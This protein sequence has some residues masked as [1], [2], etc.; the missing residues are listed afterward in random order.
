MNVL[1]NLKKKEN[2]LLFLILLAAFLM[3]AFRLGHESFWLDELHT[4]NEAAPEATIKQLFGW[5]STSDQHPPLFFFC[6]KLIFILFGS[7]EVSARLLPVLAGTASVYVLYL[8]GKELAGKNLGLIAAAFTCVNPFNIHYSREARGYM[9]AFLFAAASLLLLVRLIKCLRTHDMWYFALFSLL[10]MYSHYFGIFWVG[11]EFCVAVILYFYT[12]KTNRTRYLKRFAISAVVITAGYLAWIPFVLKM[13]QIHSFW[14]GQIGTDFVFSFFNSFYGSDG[15]LLPVMWV[16]LLF[17]V[18][19]VFRQGEQ[20]LQPPAENLLTLSFVIFFVTLGV[21]LAVPYVRSVM[22]VPMLLDR[23]TIVVLPVYLMAAAYGLDLIPNTL[24]KGLV[25]W[26]F[27]GWSFIYIVLTN[28]TYTYIHK[29][30]FREMTAYIS[31]DA[32]KRRYPVVNDRIMWQEGYYLRKDK[33][34]GPQLTGPRKEVIDSL[35]HGR[36]DKYKTDYFWIID[37]HGAGDPNAFLDTAEKRMLDSAFVLVDEQ[38]WQDAWARLYK[39]KNSN[40]SSKQMTIDDFPPA[41]V[42]DVN[43]RV[44]AI[45]GGSVTSDPFPL[46]KGSYTLQLFTWGTP[47]KGV[48]PH[49]VVSANGKVVGDFYTTATTQEQDFP[50]QNTDGDSVKITINLDNDLQSGQE[51]RNAFLK[52]IIFSKK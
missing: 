9:F 2:F 38:R 16:L 28:H 8:L 4:M 51:D 44:V 37:A 41:S 48:F 17:Y 3:R 10:A 24:V 13:S 15:F 46:S 47:A 35:V 7:S 31:F 25:F 14:I 43:G 11:S 50:F 45:W 12:A 30:Q 23:Y 52:R 36:S 5:L 29:S 39:S 21:T 20:Q 33:F 27:M 34:T 40:D 1:E 26:A 6:E 22:V 49:L 18:I 32:A 19:S 42:A